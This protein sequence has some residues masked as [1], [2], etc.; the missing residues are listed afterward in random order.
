MDSGKLYGAI[1]IPA[2]FNAS[3][4]KL[5]AGTTSVTGLPAVEIET[6][7]RA[8][9]LGS[10]LTT[11]NLT[12]LVKES[13]QAVSPA[14]FT[15]QSVVYRPL[16]AHTALGSGVFYYALLM[17]MLGFI[18]VSA[19]GPFIDGVLGF[20]ANE[21]GPKVTRRPVLRLSRVRTL[22]VKAG[23]I[24]GIAPIAA[25]V[26]QAMAAWVFTMPVDHPVELWLFGTVAI[27]A[28]GLAVSAV[29]AIFG[30]LGSL[31]SM[32]LF[33]A[34]ALTASA[35]TLP[36]QAS[37]WFFRVYSHVDPMYSI[38]RGCRAILYF[39]SA[40]DAGLVGAW[41]TVAVIGTVVFL[42]GLGVTAV[43]DR[44]PRLDRHLPLESEV[45]S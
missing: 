30:G 8:G 6:N 12:P 36:P 5:L 34:L 38:V 31:V 21:I 43:Y 42:L 3:V 14:S 16:P 19:I 9:T 24:V 33:V 44:N 39:P 7:P 23:M 41:V 45:P 15:V 1:V 37:P 10:S 32:I 35:G 27:A 4:S 20:S 28:T 17:V 29:F 22:L 25:F 13:Q 26:L 40:T 18:G 11:S 2:D